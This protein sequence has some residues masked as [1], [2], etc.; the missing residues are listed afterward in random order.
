MPLTHRLPL[1]FLIT[2]AVALGCPLLAPCFGPAAD[3]LAREAVTLRARYSAE[4]GDLTAWCREKNLLPEAKTTAD[5]AAP[6]GRYTIVLPL[7]PRDV[8]GIRAAQAASDD[9]DLW[10]RRLL[11]LR[12]DQA[13]A[14]F[15][16]AVRSARCHMG[17]L[18][19]RL[20][21]EAI[22]ADPDHE[23]ARRVFGY[24][25][26]Q[27]QWRTS[28]ELMMLRN[29]MTWSDKFGWIERVNLPRY[30]AGERLFGDTWIDAASDAALHAE[31][32]AGWDIL[33]EHYRIR[34]N[35]GIEAAVTL[36][37]KLE[38]LQRVWRQVFLR[39]YASEAEIESLFNQQPPRVEFSPRL[40][41]VYFRNKEQYHKALKPMIPDVGISMGVYV[42]ENRTAYFYAGSEDSERSMY[43]EATHQLFQ[44][45][46]PNSDNAGRRANCWLIEG[47]AMYMESLRRQGD[48]FVLGGLNDVRLQAARRHLEEGDFYVPFDKLV[49]MGKRDVQGHPH[50]AK[51]YSQIAAMASFLMHYDDGRY[52]EALVN[53]LAAIYD[54]N[55]DPDLLARATGVSYAELDNQY[56]AYMEIGAEPAR[57]N[58]K[59]GIRNPKHIQMQKSK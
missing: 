23:G 57:E 25:K 58:T 19:Y 35:R 27:K 4:L 8:G 51:L 39:Y 54:G 29:G 53:T 41:V 21:Q 59:S 16:L 32:T 18:A 22:Q 37:A 46:R 48:S 26:Y 49:R 11:K 31:I 34:T 13:A 52:R 5:L 42:P 14:L 45:S 20:A 9:R 33:T 12:Q 43:H 47:I 44:Q 2:S 38:N 56:R 30:A 55:G 17:T 28:F 10:Q 6:P 50:V 15:E 7:L 3:D 36:G 24:A 40:D 1:N